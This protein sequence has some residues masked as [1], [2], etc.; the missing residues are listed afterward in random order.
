MEYAVVD[1]SKKTKK[2]DDKQQ[3][4]C[5]YIANWFIEGFQSGSYVYS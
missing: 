4:V 2:K 5:V 1:N 3:Q